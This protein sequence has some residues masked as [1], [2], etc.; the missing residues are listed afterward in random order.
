MEKM[1]TPLETKNKQ[2]Y[3]GWY[4][5]YLPFIAKPQHMQVEWLST[6]CIKNNVMDVTGLS[7]LN[8]TSTVSLTPCQKPNGNWAFVTLQ[9]TLNLKLKQ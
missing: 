7:K 4:L 6:E 8:P 5:R 9:P 3:S 2:T 1:Q